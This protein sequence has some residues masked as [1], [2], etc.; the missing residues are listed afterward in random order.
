MSRIGNL[1]IDLPENVTISI[2]DNNLVTVKGAKGELIQ[3]INKDIKVAI[4]E[5]KILLSRPSE[6]KEH[7][8]MHGLYRSH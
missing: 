8:S 6:S 5:N 2:D 7:K 4:E 1:P 3:Q